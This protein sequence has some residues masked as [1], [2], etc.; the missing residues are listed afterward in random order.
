MKA[1][2]L[3]CFFSVT[4][5]ASDVEAFNDQ[6]PCSPIPERRI[7]FQF[8]ARNGDLVDT[9]PDPASFDGDALVALSEDAKQFGAKELNLFI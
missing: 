8:D 6:W 2:C 9:S 7:T 1:R 3:G 5:T 4:V